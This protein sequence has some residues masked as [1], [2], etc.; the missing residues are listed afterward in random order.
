MQHYPNWPNLPAMM[1]ALARTWPDKPLLRFYRDGAWHATTWREFGRMAASCA[2]HLRAA[3]VAAGDRVLIVS[4]NRPEYPIAETA[5]M[6]LRAVPVPT[7]VDQHR[8]RSRAHPAR[9][10][11]A[12]GD[13][14]LRCPRRHAARGR[15]AGGRS[16]SAGGHRG[17]AGRRRRL[18]AADAL[19]R[20]GGRSGAAGRHRAGGR[21]DP[22]E[23]ACLPDLHLRHRRRAEGR[24][25][26]APLDP[27]ELP[28]R[29]RADAAAAAPGRG[30]PVVSAD[31]AQ[32]R[33][34]RRAVLSAEYR[35]RDRLLPR[36]RA[37]GGRHADAAARP[38]SPRCRAC[39]R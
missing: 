29:V 39:S 34:H 38:S 5:L 6:A 3:G 15:T 25:A 12:G 35:H 20:T 28:R 26:A 14:V 8:G 37:S 18:A 1:F 16:R 36:R 32:L 7:Y 4:E 9:F 19:G 21:L 13:R 10:G 31:L 33:A 27:V 2:R 23:C 30:V 22:G 24:D 17:T 11:G